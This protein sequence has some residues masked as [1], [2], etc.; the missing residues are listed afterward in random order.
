MLYW[1]PNK[2][3]EE[4]SPAMNFNS[5]HTKTLRMYVVMS[6]LWHNILRHDIC[7]IYT[8]FVR[9]TYISS[10]YSWNIYQGF[11]LKSMSFYHTIGPSRFLL[12]ENLNFLNIFFTNV[13]I[14]Y[15]KQFMIIVFLNNFLI[16][17]KPHLINES[18]N[19]KSFTSLLM[20]ANP[21]GSHH[22]LSKEN[23]IMPAL[24][25]SWHD[26]WNI[27][28]NWHFPV[29]IAMTAVADCYLSMS[30]PLSLRWFFYTGE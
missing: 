20:L 30:L 29:N 11:S 14:H 24:T 2:S 4:R 16:K 3:A 12:L 19:N 5:Y 21:N 10:S 22:Y 23:V 26:P 27:L 8:Y 18:S 28:C 6:A 1:T 17:I 7:I 25:F 9:Y 15:K 13:M